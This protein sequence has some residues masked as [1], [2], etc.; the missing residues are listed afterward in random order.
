MLPTCQKQEMTFAKPYL[1]VLKDEFRDQVA[2]A[3]AF[4][5]NFGEAGAC[6][7]KFLSRLVPQLFSIGETH[8]GLY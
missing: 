2:V 8:R 3:H 4:N 1:A 7:R 5:P 6:K